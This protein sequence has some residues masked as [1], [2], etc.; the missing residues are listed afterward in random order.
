MLLLMNLSYVK[1]KTVSMEEAEI[2][3][4]AGN[5][6]VGIDPVVINYSVEDMACAEVMG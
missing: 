3:Y 1:E 2:L 5:V 4:P 6:L